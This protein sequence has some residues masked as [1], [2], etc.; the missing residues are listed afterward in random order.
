MGFNGITIQKIV[1]DF[2]LCNE[3]N[4]GNVFSIV[5]PCTA[6]KRFCG[7]GG[8]FAL[9]RVGVELPGKSPARCQ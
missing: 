4:V 7:Q 8:A 9:C 5:F 1:H 3:M 2:L 6:H